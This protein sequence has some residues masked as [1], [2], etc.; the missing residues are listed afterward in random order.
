MVLAGG[1]MVAPATA[2]VHVLMSSPDHVGSAVPVLAVLLLLDRAPA[3]WWVP[4][5]AGVVLAWGLVADNVLLVTAVLPLLAICGGRVCYT[6]IRRKPLRSRWLELSLI[7]AAVAAVVLSSGILA[8]IAA[9]GGFTIWPVRAKLVAWAR[10][11][12]H[13]RVLPRGLALLFGATTAGHASALT[14]GLGLLH[15]AG[16]GVAIWG[17]GTALWRFRRLGLVDQLIVGSI[18]INLLTYIL[19]TP[20]DLLYSARDY[21]VVLPLS[22]ALAGRMVGERLLSARVAPVAVAVLAGYVLSLAVGVSAPPAAQPRD[23]H[24]ARWLLAHHLDYGL[25]AYGTGNALTLYAR[26]HVHVV[27]VTFAGGRCYPFAWETQASGYDARLHDATFVLQA[28]PSATIRKVFGT[29]D[30]VYQ[31]GSTRVFVWHKNL[32]REVQPASSRPGHGT[33][34]NHSLLP[35]GL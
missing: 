26:D 16:L 35:G 7:G 33:P 31:V 18:L 10:V 29:P 15:V 28:A 21:S 24:L 8:V 32:L 2:A 11:L 9:H 23:A 30:H 1:I 6:V 19:L 3:R 27:V 20:G 13:L 17:F 4:I 14:I 34:H 12:A 5:L 22:A 25:G